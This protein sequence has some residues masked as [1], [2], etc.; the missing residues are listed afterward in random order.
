MRTKWWTQRLPASRILRSNS[1]ATGNRESP[2]IFAKMIYCCES[3]VRLTENIGNKGFSIVHAI[4]FGDR[5]FCLSMRPFDKDV[6]EHYS[7]INPLTGKNG[8]PYIENKNGEARSM[9]I[10]LN[11]LINFCPFCGYPLQQIID[12]NISE[13]DTMS[14][15]QSAL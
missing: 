1:L 8:W 5:R 6:Y 7:S 14:M 11:Q 12:R 3:F 15:Q 10:V 13:F 9:G 4:H 2:L